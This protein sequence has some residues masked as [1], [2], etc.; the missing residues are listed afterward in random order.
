VHW[1]KRCCPFCGLSII[2]DDPAKT[3]YHE[4]PEC[5][6]FMNLCREVD[7]A[8]QRGSVLLVEPTLEKKK[9]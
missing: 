6:A 1:R 3:V 7:P 4:T 8:H 5:L 9:S 2:L